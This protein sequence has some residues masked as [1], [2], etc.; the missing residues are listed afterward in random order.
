MSYIPF[1]FE[2][3]VVD[4][5][6]GPDSPEERIALEHCIEIDRHERCLPVV[7]VDDIRAE[8][9]EGKR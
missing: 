9:Y 3:Y 6:Y 8:T 7:A 5:E 4:C 1:A 2:S